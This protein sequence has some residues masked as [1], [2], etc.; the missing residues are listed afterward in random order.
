M[1]SP[2]EDLLTVGRPPEEDEVRVLRDDDISVQPV[3]QRSVI[4]GSGG[5]SVGRAVASKNRDPR[6]KSQHRQNF[7]YQL[8]I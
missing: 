6:F 2:G 5:V 7:I 8:Y 4:A 3:D 1:R